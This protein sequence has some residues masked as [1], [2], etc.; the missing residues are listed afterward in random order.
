MYYWSPSECTSTPWPCRCPLLHE[1]SH[2]DP[3]G[4]SMRPFPCSR[5]FFHSPLYFLPSR[6]TYICVPSYSC[7]CNVTPHTLATIYVSPH[8]LIP[9]PLAWP[10]TYLPTYRAPFEDVICPCPCAWPVSNEPSY[11][12][13]CPNRIVPHPRISPGTQ[14]LRCQYLYFCTSKSSTFV[15]VK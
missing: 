7:Y 5:A 6:H 3:S 15:L 11:R 8:T 13:P 12:S 4:H 10:S 2:Q 9:W 14:L 1:P